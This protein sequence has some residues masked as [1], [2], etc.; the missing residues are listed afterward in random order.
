[1][2]VTIII[3]IIILRL[4]YNYM[5]VC[6]VRYNLHSKSYQEYIIPSIRNAVLRWYYQLSYVIPTFIS[7]DDL[8]FIL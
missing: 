4:Y 1:M 6:I 8:Y 7:S 2:H 5:C 3:I